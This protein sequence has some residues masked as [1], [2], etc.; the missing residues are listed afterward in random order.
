LINIVHLTTDLGL[1]GR[2][3]VIVDIANSLR[4]RNYNPS[5][6]CLY[7]SG[8]WADYLDPAIEVVEF[9]K[10][11]KLDLSVIPRIKSYLCDHHIKILHCHNPGT[12]LY[13]LLAAKWAKTQLII[14][15]EHGFSYSLSWKSRLKDQILYKYLDYM[16]VVSEKLKNDLNSIYRLKPNRIKI[17]RNAI[18]PTIMSEDKNS[19]RKI[20]GMSIQFFN[21]GI[22]GRLVP[23]K[24][25]RMILEAVSILIQN[26]FPVRLWIVGSGELQEDLFNYTQKLGIEEAVIFMGSRTDVP[27]IL[28]ALDLFILCS[29]SE[30]LSVTLLEAMSAGLPII[31]TNVGGNSEVIQHEETGLLVELNQTVKMAEFI[32]NLM[33]DR[34]KARRLGENAQIRFFKAFNIDRMTSEIE[35]L[36]QLGLS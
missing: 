32:E 12:L 35:C 16:T 34:I 14:D 17:I 7:E 24:N 5:I 9:H 10:K 28:N 23:V 26:N 20:Y 15:T 21:I 19:S 22:V 1:A 6:L 31:A 11:K 33:K 36:Y 13:G 2:E 30:G 8:S 27:R 29:N 18:Q 3:R 4:T 25:H